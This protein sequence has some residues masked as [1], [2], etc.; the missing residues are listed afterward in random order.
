[1]RRGVALLALILWSGG[2]QSAEVDVSSWE[3]FLR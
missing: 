3:T 2:L 1:M